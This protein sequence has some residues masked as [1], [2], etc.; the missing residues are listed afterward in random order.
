V[1]NVD[2]H[3]AYLLAITELKASGELAFIANAVGPLIEIMCCSRI[4]DS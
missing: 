4:I 2:G 1:I 3:P